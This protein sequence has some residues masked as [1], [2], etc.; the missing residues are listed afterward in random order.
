[1]RALLLL[2]LLGVGACGEPVLPPWSC[3]S[4]GNFRYAFKASSHTK[5]VLTTEGEYNV[6]AY[7]NAR[8]GANVDLCTRGMQGNDRF[9]RELRIEG[10]SY[11]VVQ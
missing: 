6:W 3:E 1:M 2:L 7:V 9:R 8:W 5:K 10:I 11:E 4:V